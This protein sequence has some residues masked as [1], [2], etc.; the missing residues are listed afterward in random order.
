MPRPG[1]RRSRLKCS[2][3]L[4]GAAV[5]PAARRRCSR[6][7]LRPFAVEAGRDP[8]LAHRR[9]GRSRA[10]PR[11]RRQPAA[12]PLPALPHRAVPGGALPGQSR[13]DLAG[14]GARLSEG[15]LRL[16]L[17]DGG[18]FNPDTIMPSYYRTDGLEP[19]RRRPGGQADPE[20]RADRG[21]GGL[22][23]DPDGLSRWSR[24]EPRAN[25]TA[26]PPRGARGRRWRSSLVARPRRRPR[27]PRR[28]RAIRRR[29]PTDQ[30]GPG[31]ARPAAA[32][33]ER[34]RR[35]A[36][37]QRREPDDA[38]PTTSRPSHVFTEK[39]PQPNVASFRLG[40]ARRPRARGDPHPPR[41]HAE[42]RRR[43]PS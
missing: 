8:A 25:S 13:P 41:R 3:E 42:D 11:H 27:P 19:G 36:D 38:R 18:R 20:R 28:C 15:Q 37:G 39:N 35:A 5:A 23:D 16:R 10:R 26:H 4:R 34:Q 31:Q 9:A 43:S 33:R 21:R 14:A 1:S 22:P 40:A 2:A 30:E 17:V 32:G 29:W 12:G 6:R 7:A 24:D